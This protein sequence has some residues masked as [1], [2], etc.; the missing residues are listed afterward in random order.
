MEAV[1]V[2]MGILMWMWG[3]AGLRLIQQ[4]L[5]PAAGTTRSAWLALALAIGASGLV[6]LA[7]VVLPASVL[8]QGWSRETLQSAQLWTAGVVA[9]VAVLA[10]MRGHRRLSPV[11]RKSAPPAPVP[12]ARAASPKAK[13]RP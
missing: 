4:A 12:A 1:I 13:R 9:A 3:E 8:S 6:A 11:L 2:A 5:P 7:Q 10:L